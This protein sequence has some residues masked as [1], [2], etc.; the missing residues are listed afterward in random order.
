[1]STRRGSRG[2]DRSRPTH[3]RIQ[4]VLCVLVGAHVDGPGGHVAQQHRP[5]AAVQAAHTI[6]E[7]DDARGAG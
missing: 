3:M 6:F 5:Q 2:C 7:P 1:V 4:K